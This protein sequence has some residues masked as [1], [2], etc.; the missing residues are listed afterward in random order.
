MNIYDWLWSTL[1]NER[2]QIPGTIP[3]ETPP[4]EP[5]D[6]AE[7]APSPTPGDPPVGQDSFLT[8]QQIMDRIKGNPDLE[9]V[10]K[11]MQGA[12]TRKTQGIAKVRDAASIVDRFNSDPE[13]AR[14]TILQRAAQLGIQVGGTQAASPQGAQ[15]AQVPPQLVEAVRGQLGDELK[16]MAP[17]LAASQWAGMQYALQPIQQQQAQSVRSTFDQQFD[18]LAESLSEKAPGWEQHEDDMDGLLAFLKSDKMTDRRWGSKLELLYRAVVGPGMATAQAAQRMAQAGKNKVST[19]QATA[20]AP[21]DISAQVR[22]PKNMQ[23]AW[24][25]AAKHAVSAL[26]KQGIKVS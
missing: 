5:A 8:D 19:G 16:W 26:E 18:Q 4:A 14:Q 6:P 10:F 12:Y 23:D 1:G 24:D 25:I 20:T 15:G 7:P 13:F 3:D 11:K 22:Q 9:H 21:P 17:M 2:G